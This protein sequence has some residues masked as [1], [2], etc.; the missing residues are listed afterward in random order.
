SK[1]YNHKTK[2]LKSISNSK[3]KL[4]EV[5]DSILLS[6]N[7]MKSVPKNRFVTLNNPILV[8]NQIILASKFKEKIPIY[9]SLTLT[10]LDKQK[11]STYLT[12]LNILKLLCIELEMNSEEQKIEK[13]IQLFEQH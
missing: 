6:L 13:A 10:Y 4:K 8:N 12:W 5:I 9:Q 1:L 7:V 3:E 11:R 2:Q